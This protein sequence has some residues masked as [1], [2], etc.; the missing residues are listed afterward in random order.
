M[1]VE[2]IENVRMKVKIIDLSCNSIQ[3]IAMQCILPNNVIKYFIY[4][5]RWLQDINSTLCERTS[6]SCV[7]ER[8]CWKGE[9]GV[10]GVS[11][12]FIEYMY[13]ISLKLETCIHFKHILTRP[14][15][16]EDKWRCYNTSLLLCKD[17]VTDKTNNLEALYVWSRNRVKSK[18]NF[19]YNL[20]D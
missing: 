3:T 18:F 12:T 17:K 14:W 20:G 8:W 13:S 2:K 9:A 15:A 6:N 5:V 11:S 10:A 4:L 1:F 19:L 16:K 7:N